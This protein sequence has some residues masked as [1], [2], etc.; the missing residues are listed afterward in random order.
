MRTRVA[1]SRG[2]PVE[3]DRPM[4]DGTGRGWRAYLALAAV[5][6]PL[7]VPA[8]PGQSA[9]L[10]V[11]NLIA[12]AVFFVVTMAGYK[13]RVPLAVPMLTIAAGSLLATL[14]AP[15]IKLVALS[16]IQDVYLFAWFVVLVN[17]LR[18]ERDLRLVR[19]AWMWTAAAV[20]VVALTQLFLRYGTL[21]TLLGSRGLRP[22]ATLYNPN[23]L[24]DYMVISLFITV[25]L[26]GLVRRRVLWPVLALLALALLST[27]SNGGMISFAAGAM[28][29]I[30][31]RAWTARVPV[32]VLAAVGLLSLGVLGFGAWLNKE[33]GVG[34]GLLASL[35][36]HTFAGRMEHSSES[37]MRIWDQLERSYA[38]SPLGIGPGNSG[39][40]TLTIAERER[41][42]SY[43]SKEAHS[44]YLAYA[45]ER[46]PLGIIG[47]VALTVVMFF[48]VSTYWRHR[49]HR[50]VARRRY[51][52]W[53][54]A[55]AAALAASAVHSTVIEKLHFRHFWLFAA[56]VVASALVSARRSERR[57]VVLET[58]PGPV[59]LRPALTSGPRGRLLARGMAS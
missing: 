26:T 55:M 4:A 3:A 20:A 14:G 16:L 36:E 19:V 5:L 10:D 21:A 15:S 2:L 47:L 57:P 37:R 34:N 59:T 27:K 29:W 49:P 58:E 6:A 45:I 43:R 53:T 32:R 9:L 35:Q 30:M 41:P 50:G 46:G 56:L 17:V 8:G 48:Q 25:S 40:L 18:T 51:A 44:D 38:R 1:P 39:A 52:R 11:V 22:P 28:V 42:D 13:L 54:A 33:W 31:V 7:C 12:L 24:A 23:M